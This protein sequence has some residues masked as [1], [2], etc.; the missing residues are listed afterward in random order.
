MVV[1]SE[2]G[3]RIVRLTPLAE[4]LAAIE[5]RVRPV[6]PR[7]VNTVAALGRILAADAAASARQPAAALALR[8]GWAVKSNE[9]ADAGSYAPA[10]LSAVPARVAIGEPVPQGAD[11]VAPV[12]AVVCRGKT[13]EA[14]APVASGEGVLSAGGDVEAGKSLRH[15][16]ERL[17]AI[18]CAVLSAAGILRVS[19]REPRIRLTRGRTNG[20]A[21]IAASYA[22]LADTLTAEGAA[23]ILDDG[24]E[25][26]A[27]HLEAA[28]QHVTSD[29]VVIL[30]G[31]GSETSDISAATLAKI[32]R[33]EF[34]GVGLI[35]GE[36]SGFGFV[37]ARPVLLI[38]GRID[39]ALAVWLILGRQMFRRLAA[40]SEEEAPAM[41]EL[42]RKVTSTVGM[43]EVVPV[44]R[45]GDQAEPLAS[46]YLSFSTLARADGWILVPADSEGYPAGARVAVRLLA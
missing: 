40:R 21:A 23:V 11:A 43:A 45:S 1:Y 24:G 39:A 17:R 7:K 32:G 5:A 25:P 18:D 2:P 27:S 3:Q 35:P 8:D 12:E 16:G 15:A 33:V 6:E 42:T 31:T 46:G 41:A 44:R 30:G 20:T 4:A 37:G 22:W 26:A 19:V 36:T 29:A 14:L 28:L 38:P 9:T 10:P 13:A 34:H